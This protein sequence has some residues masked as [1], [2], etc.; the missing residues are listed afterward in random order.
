MS[1]YPYWPKVYGI[2]EISTG[3]VIWDACIYTSYQKCLREFNKYK[4][5]CAEEG[6]EIRYYIAEYDLVVGD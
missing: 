4:E 1:K 5:A 6:D 2:A 3:D